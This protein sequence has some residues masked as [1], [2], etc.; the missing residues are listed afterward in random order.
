M[1][2]IARFKSSPK[3]FL[4]RFESTHD[5]IRTEE[6]H[7]IIVHLL[8]K[9]D[10]KS[11]VLGGNL[12]QLAMLACCSSAHVVKRALDAIMNEIFL[13]ISNSSRIRCHNLFKA[14]KILRESF[15]NFMTVDNM[16]AKCHRMTTY[17]WII[18]L[19]LVKCSKEECIGILRKIKEFEKNTLD[20]LQN[21]REYSG[22]NTFQ[23]G[24]YLARESIKRISGRKESRESL[25]RSMKKCE[26]LLNSKVEKD[27][28][29]KLGKAIHNGGSWMDLHVCLVFLQ[30][31][32]KV[33]LIKLEFQELCFRTCKKVIFIYRPVYFMRKRLKTYS[34]NES[35]RHY[36]VF[37]RR[38]FFETHQGVF[39]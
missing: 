11:P 24:I 9:C 34:I 21:N 4:D 6:D 39:N 2:K 17:S 27:E 5:E 10:S 15:V 20:A 26:N 30:D 23:Y 36:E 14:E 37:W 22:R 3:E 12:E 32:P 19:V 18:T 35:V 29:M 8:N 1:R 38:Y 7:F 13:S 31:L 25:H 16:K 28:V 33:G